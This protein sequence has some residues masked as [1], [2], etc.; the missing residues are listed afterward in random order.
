MMLV[1]TGVRLLPLCTFK[2]KWI[3]FVEVSGSICS[4]SCS[5]E[6]WGEYLPP[7]VPPDHTVLIISPLQLPPALAPTQRPQ[8][9][10]LGKVKPFISTSVSLTPWSFI[11]F[12][13][14]LSRQE[15]DVSSP[16][17]GP[18]DTAPLSPAHS[19]QWGPVTTHGISKLRP[20]RLWSN[21]HLA[22]EEMSPAE[23]V[24]QGHTL[25]GVRDG[26]RTETG[27]S[28]LFVHFAVLS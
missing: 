15:C 7:Q 19:R 21:Q 28:L 17:I 26:R 2:V 6:G 20:K 14:F 4:F 16:V 1:V 22:D 13:R 9:K 24:A 5:K 11:A 27:S 18:N 12:M 3:V 25:D 10:P 23:W 8:W